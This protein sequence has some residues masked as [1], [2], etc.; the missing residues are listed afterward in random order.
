M[1]SLLVVL[2]M[3][4]A[5]QAPSHSPKFHLLE[6]IK[7]KDGFAELFS[8]EEAAELVAYIPSY[9]ECQNLGHWLIDYVPM[10]DLNR[11][12]VIKDGD[13]SVCKIFNGEW[14]V[15]STDGLKAHIVYEKT[16]LRLQTQLNPQESDEADGS[17]K[18]RWCTITDEIGFAAMFFPE[19]ATELNITIPSDE[20]CPELAEWVVNNVPLRDT[21]RFF[22]MEGGQIAV[23]KPTNG[24]WAVGPIAKGQKAHI[25]YK[26]L[27]P[28]T[29][30][31]QF[32]DCYQFLCLI[33][34]VDGFAELIS[35]EDALQFDVELP[36]QEECPAFGNWL[37]DDL[38]IRDDSSF[39]VMVNK[40]YAVCKLID[41]VWQVAATKSNEKSHIVYFNEHYHY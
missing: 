1:R 24:I 32:D 5:T 25:F 34:G 11:F 21:N 37:V 8:T 38:L 2:L 36:S 40:Q 13:I 4:F 18:S 30:K 15:T 10:R 29:P 33:R 14:G 19:G 23:C 31:P 35:P 39:Y 9:A 6:I 41:G 16:Y 20:K 12:F 7:D 3:L 17:C 26:N 28:P 27:E 22:V